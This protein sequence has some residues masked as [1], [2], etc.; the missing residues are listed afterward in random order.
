G[1]PRPPLGNCCRCRRQRRPSAAAP[2]SVRT[3]HMGPVRLPHRREPTD[4]PA[5]M[6]PSFRPPTAC[7]MPLRGCLPGRHHASRPPPPGRCPPPAAA[8]L[9][10]GR[11]LRCHTPLRPASGPPP[12]PPPPL[13]APPPKQARCP[14]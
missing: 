9:G 4:S 1:R 11:P 14:C 8:P 2:L 12:T 6:P 3:V 13:P 7:P 5:A 10:R